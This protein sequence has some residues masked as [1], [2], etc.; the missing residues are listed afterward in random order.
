MLMRAVLASDFIIV[1]NALFFI[2][3]ESSPNPQASPVMDNTRPMMGLCQSKNKSPTHSRS[4]SSDTS[5]HPW[6]S[7]S[8]LYNP[9]SAEEQQP[10]P[11]VI[12]PSYQPPP[13]QRTLSTEDIEQIHRLECKEDF[14]HVRIFIAA[15]SSL[16]SHLCYSH[17]S[18]RLSLL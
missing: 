12:S 3:M 14:Q 16:L 6:H 2:S 9:G 13:L 8:E 17:S 11:A 7:L 10:I 4:N 1:Q 18:V 15:I 5:D